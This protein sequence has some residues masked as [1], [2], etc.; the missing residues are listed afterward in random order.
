MLKSK[1]SKVLPES[2]DFLF[3]D[4][5]QEEIPFPFFISF[6]CK[7]KKVSERSRF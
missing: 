5:L 7:G 6:L 1:F 2:S 4:Y 3:D